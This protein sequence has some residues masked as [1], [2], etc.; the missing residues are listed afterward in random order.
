MT[1]KYLTVEMINS[2]QAN[3]FIDQVK[4]KTQEK[5]LFDTLLFEEKVLQLIKSY[6]L[7]IRPRLNP[8]CDYLLICK[9]GR[10]LNNLSSIFGRMVYAG[11]R[12]RVR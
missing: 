4:F 11:M 7:Q 9:R 3:G 2:V 8:T 10:Q 6:I 1:F 12:F 5:Y